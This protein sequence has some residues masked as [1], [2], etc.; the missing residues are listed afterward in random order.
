[1]RGVR[2]RLVRRRYRRAQT[3]ERSVA[4]VESPT[5]HDVRPIDDVPGR[6][7]EAGRE[8]SRD[9]VDDLGQLIERRARPVELPSAVIGQEDTGAADLRRDRADRCPLRG[10]LPHHPHRSLAHLG[11]ITNR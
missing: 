5:P 7:G 10:M 6:C 2:N 11:R 8:P 9:G 4:L 3:V 1:M